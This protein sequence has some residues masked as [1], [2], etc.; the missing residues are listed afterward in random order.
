MIIWQNLDFNM[1]LLIH[2]NKEKYEEISITFSTFAE[3]EMTLKSVNTTF[4]IA[5]TTILNDVPYII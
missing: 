2:V 1:I 5:E 4:H 3:L